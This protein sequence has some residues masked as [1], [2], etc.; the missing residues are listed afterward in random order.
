MAVARKDVA[1]LVRVGRRTFEGPPRLAVSGVDSAGRG[2]FTLG[3]AYDVAGIAQSLSVTLSGSYDDV[4]SL[5]DMNRKYSTGSRGVL[6]DSQRLFLVALVGALVIGVIA[7]VFWTATRSLS[8]LP[9]RKLAA[10][11][12]SQLC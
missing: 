12:S 5:R 4:M 2:L 9:S 3:A 10:A 6:A 11:R 7:F 1:R 8:L